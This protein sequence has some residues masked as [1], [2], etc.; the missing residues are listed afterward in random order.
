MPGLVVVAV[1]KF[2]LNNPYLGDDGG[3]QFEHRCQLMTI[4]VDHER[5]DLR[6]TGYHLIDLINR[7]T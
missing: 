5:S 3:R 1:R 6:T 4:H 2:T 7:L